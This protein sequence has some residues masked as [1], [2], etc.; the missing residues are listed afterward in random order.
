MRAAKPNR[1]RGRGRKLLFG[2][3]LA[4]CL[5]LG[6]ELLVAAI[7]SES[8]PG[9]VWRLGLRR[10]GDGPSLLGRDPLH[11]A[12]LREFDAELGWDH[13]PRGPARKTS[14]A[15]ALVS[16]YGDSFTECTGPDD[17]TWEALLANLLHA[18][19]INFGVSAYGPDQALLKLKR[20]YPQYPTPVVLFG[21]LSRD[22]SR[23]VNV[24]G[25][26][27]LLE[28]TGTFLLNGRPYFMPTKPR[29]VLTD[30]RLRLLE[31]PVKTEDDFMRLAFEPGYAQ[32]FS[33]NDHFKNGYDLDRYYPQVSFPYALTLPRALWVQARNRGPIP[34]HAAML[35]Q[36]DRATHLLK[37]IFDEFA[38]V[39]QHNS[40][41]G[42]VVLFGEADEL[43]Y[44]LQ[45]GRHRRLDP[46]VGYLQE[47]GYRY[48]DTVD[49]LARHQRSTRPPEPISLYFD[50]TNHHSAYA[51]KIIAEGIEKYL[52]PHLTGMAR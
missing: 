48:V 46:I 25:S 3:C 10:P 40:F 4:A 47:K 20:F 26:A 30:G 37:A 22:I 36:D 14:A 23:I 29:Y 1:S 44:Y 51:H 15:P 18:D 7:I 16:A 9:L 42:V 31:N 28:E 33:D 6:F 27:R 43:A 11:K 13:P 50:S 21:Y 38:G 32:T 45:Q 24:Y 17:L 5:W 41:L 8:G 12:Y 2:T 49:L 19:V 39:S 52:S 34:D 35:M